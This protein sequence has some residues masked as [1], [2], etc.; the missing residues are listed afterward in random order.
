[1]A[2]APVPARPSE[3]RVLGRATAWAQAMLAQPAVQVAWRTATWLAQIV[4]KRGFVA[5]LCGLVVQQYIEVPLRYGLRPAEPPSV[6]LG[7]AWVTGLMAW[8]LAVFWVPDRVYDLWLG[9][10][11]QYKTLAWQLTALLGIPPL[12]AL[13]L[14][15]LGLAR[16]GLGLAPGAASGSGSGS[17]HGQ[18]M[19]RQ[20]YMLA[21]LHVAGYMVAYWGCVLLRGAVDS[22]SDAI[23]D[24]MYL[25]STELKD[26]EPDAPAA[27]ASGAGA[28]AEAR[29]DAA[30]DAGAD[31]AAAAAAD[32][33]VDADAD[34]GADADADADANTDTHGARPMA[35]RLHAAQSDDA[36]AF[37]HDP[38]PAATRLNTYETEGPIP[39]AWLRR[40]RAAGT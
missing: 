4:F 7:Q 16:Y 34:A 11:P 36:N 10:R 29:G 5:L 9:E 32:A 26:Y 13:A 28:G 39:D 2:P 24:E 35:A 3:A 6:S 12:A 8:R 21:G 30:R 19:L 1:M 40:P 27:P 22:W 15:K 20:A 31:T 17:G 18:Y 33:D 14:A 37:D 25:E 23:R 38:P